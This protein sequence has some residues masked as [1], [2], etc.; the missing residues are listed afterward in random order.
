MPSKVI[1]EDTVEST[2]A[3]ERARKRIRFALNMA[4]N[5]FLDFDTMDEICRSLALAL[6]DLDEVNLVAVSERRAA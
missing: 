4:E 1:T 3:L 2:Q 6:R 5:G